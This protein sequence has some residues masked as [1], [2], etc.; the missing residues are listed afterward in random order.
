M[1]KFFCILAACGSSQ[2]FFAVATL[3]ALCLPGLQLQRSGL[4]PGAALM[5]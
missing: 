1:D 4:L 3:A 5:D 2:C